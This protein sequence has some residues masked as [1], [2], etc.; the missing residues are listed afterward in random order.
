VANFAG[1]GVNGERVSEVLVK[2]YADC[3]FVRLLGEGGCPDTS[4]VVGTNY[5]DIGWVIDARTGR[6]VL[7]SAEDNLGKGAAS[8]AIQSFNLMCGLEESA[9]LKKF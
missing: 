1:G 5:I 2:A 9:G 3:Q 4:K 6:C 8:Q 7:M